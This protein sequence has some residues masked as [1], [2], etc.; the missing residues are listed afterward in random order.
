MQLTRPRVLTR[1]R[2]PGG[3]TL[4]TGWCRRHCYGRS[5]TAILWSW[6][7]GIRWRRLRG[8]KTA[9]SVMGRLVGGI[10]LAG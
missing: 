10:F 7:E 6:V 5:L 3:T 4:L 8:W 1:Y 2:A 9:C